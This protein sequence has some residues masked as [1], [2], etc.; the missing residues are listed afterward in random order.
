MKKQWSVFSDE[1]SE[2]CPRMYLSGVRS[3]KSRERE[4]GG[5]GEA[6]KSPPRCSVSPILRFVSY[7]YSCFLLFTIHCSLFTVLTSCGY[8]IAGK[9]GN[10]PGN[11]ATLSIPF[12]KNRLKK[13]AVEQVIH[14]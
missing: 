10:M 1:W 2:A 9:G 13:H 3:Q 5:N 7:S 6:G 14:S 8:H 11:I 4:K 12:F